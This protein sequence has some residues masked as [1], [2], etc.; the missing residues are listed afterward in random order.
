ME[1]ITWI[2]QP[3][4]IIA[5]VT[6]TTLEVILG[7]DNLVF[8]SVLADRLPEPQQKPARQVGLI[9]AMVTR[10]LLLF[11][12]T[13]V[14]SLTF[15]IFEVPFGDGEIS[16]RDLI[17]ILGGLF[18]L[19]KA[20]F[21]IHHAL[22]GEEAQH[23]ARVRASFGAVIAQIALLDLV[24]SL[25]SVITAVGMTDILP[26]MVTAVVLAVVVM[27]LTVEQVSAYIKRHPTVKILALS[28]LLLIGTSLVAE[29]LGTHFPKGYIYFAMAFSIFVDLLQ[30]RVQP[31]DRKPVALRQAGLSPDGEGTAEE[32]AAGAAASVAEPAPEG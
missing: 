24:F 31:K 32:A 4:A 3:E 28:F 30:M 2:T 10:I 12:L 22:E 16:G 9:V 20:T 17:L 29:G 5:L 26:V 27:L 13:W 25:D 21:E 6:L 7:I 11:S 14:L 15:G 23:E 1:W 18:L 8:I 19:G